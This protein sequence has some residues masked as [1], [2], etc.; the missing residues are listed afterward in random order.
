MKKN[1]DR[2]N[3][4]PVELSCI[5]PDAQQVCIGGTFN[6]WDA[7]AT[8]LKKTAGGVW[9]IS[10]QLAPGS[11]EYKFLVDG[12]WICE[13]GVDEYDPQLRDS[14]DYVPNA[15]GSMNRKLEV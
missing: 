5:A 12:N 10:L 15:H 6:G 8:P 13:P 1:R 4:R 11:Y 2:R 9:R 14:A 3:L 7:N